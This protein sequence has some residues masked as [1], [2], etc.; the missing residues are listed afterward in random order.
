MKVILVLLDGLG[1][2]SYSA[3]NHRTPLEAADTPNLDR[4]AELGGN[5]LFHPSSLGLCF[6]SEIAHFLLFGYDL[7]KFPGRGLLEAVGEGV[8]FDNDDVLVLAHISGVI[9]EN[10]RPVLTLG[11]DHIKGTFK[12]IG[13]LYSLIGNFESD[14]ISIRLQQTRRN[15]AILILNGPVSPYISDS[16]P[17]IL[18]K[19]ISKIVPLSENPELEKSRFTA[20]ALNHYL[21]FC[22]HQLN[23]TIIRDLSHVLK[24]PAEYF[25]V[26]QRSGRRINLPSFQQRWGVNGLMMASS[27]VYGGLAHEL[28]I[29]YQ[30]VQDSDDPGM[31]LK[32]RIRLALFDT[33]HDFIHVHTKVPDEAAHT[34]EPLY[35]MNQI[36]RLDRGLKELVQVVENEK[37]L[38]V[39][40]TADHSTP[41]ISPMIH[42]GEPVPV[43]MA[44]QTVRR[45]DVEHFSEIQAA[46]G[47]LGLLRGA[48]LMYMIL[49]FSNR[50]NL[51]GHQL[52]PI[53]RDYLPS[54]DE[55]YKL[56]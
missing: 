47:C 16:D 1:D 39:V 27:S 28:G 54:D 52:G 44:G 15:D 18:G 41:S 25:L 34:G 17:I 3:L 26:T 19:P 10:N 49:N 4:L 23:S 51:Y 30:S 13:R 9:W 31:D 14:G 55:P 53:Q 2:R 24:P 37:D 29:D 46:R 42:S 12:D 36:S 5:G 45:D 50:G 35:K 20:K 7:K 48:E 21:T 22:Y 56:I 43:V 40:V 8:S 38:L 33:T 11:R 6:P 32:D